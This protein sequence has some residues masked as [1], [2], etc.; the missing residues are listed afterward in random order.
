MRN[1]FSIEQPLWFTHAQSIEHT[2]RVMTERKTSGITFISQSTLNSHT[3]DAAIL[4]SKV[5]LQLD[6]ISE[7]KKDT[8]WEG[9]S[10]KNPVT[11]RQFVIGGNTSS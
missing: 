4:K 7:K 8:V 3:E 5:N 9:E 1:S 11:V 6:F 2:L 10:Y